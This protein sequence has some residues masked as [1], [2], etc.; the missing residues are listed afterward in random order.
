M[1]SSFAHDS[2]EIRMGRQGRIVIPAGLRSSLGLEE[3]TRLLVRVE[4][5]E[6]RITTIAQSVAHARAQVTALVPQDVNLIDELIAERRADA[7]SE[8]E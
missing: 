4:R 3:G 5:D 2:S 1:S 7:A 8:A 6:L